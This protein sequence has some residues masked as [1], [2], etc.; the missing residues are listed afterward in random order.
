[1]K[2]A[3]DAAG[4]WRPA[5]GLPLRRVPLRLLSFDIAAAG[6]AIVA[7]VS[8]AR[9]QGATQEMVSGLAVSLAALDRGALIAVA[10]FV[11]VV[12]FAATTAIVHVRYRMGAARREAATLGEIARLEA[13]IEEGR[14]LLLAEP[15]I[16]VVWRDPAADPEI[17]GNTA[18]FTGVVA[19]SRVL[20]FGAWL[21]PSSAREA[22]EAVDRLRRRGTALSLGLVTHDGR[23]IEAE[24]RPVGSAVVLRLREVT[25]VRVEL[26]R[27]N[28]EHRR[29]E[30][31]SAALRA[32]L[33]ALPA[34]AW[35]RGGDGRLAWINAAYAHAVEARDAAD[36]TSRSLSLLD[37]PTRQAAARAHEAGRPFAQRS[38]RR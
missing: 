32:L 15:Q 4:M 9:A 6:L 11:G 21:A 29:L 37:A 27:L 31:D 3:Q 5:G 24:G 34:P 10:L 36:A 8:P 20:A 38:R 16:I 30:A 25:G 14:A 1:M 19:P 2:G 13:Q 7:A 22:E 33:E 23:H 35:V 26:A 12:A 17:I 28:E 18:A